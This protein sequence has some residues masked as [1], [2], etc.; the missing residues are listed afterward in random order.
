MN[1]HKIV[2]LILRLRSL[3]KKIIKGESLNTIGIIRFRFT[4]VLQ[5]DLRLTVLRMLE[6]M[7]FQ[8]KLLELMLYLCE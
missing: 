5:I 1:S 4:E 2:L 6:F 3:M 8:F 7:M